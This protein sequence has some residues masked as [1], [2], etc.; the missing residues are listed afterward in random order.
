MAGTGAGSGNRGGTEG[1]A[2]DV[3][4]K[5]LPWSQPAPAGIH[6]LHLYTADSSAQI[7][8][9]YATADA[10]PR[11]ADLRAVW[12]KRWNKRP[13][14][15]LLVAAY[16]TADGRQATVVGLREKPSVGS[17]PIGA[18]ERAIARALEEQDRA[19]A[20]EILAGLLAEHDPDAIPGLVNDGLFATYE[21]QHRVPER[22]DFAGAGHSVAAV[23]KVHGVDV[24]TALGWT[25]TP[26]GS[27]YLLG[28]DGRHEAVAVVLEGSEVFERSSAK[29]GGSTP[30]E[31]ALAVAHRHRVTWVLAV[32]GTLVR[33][34]SADP[35][36]GIA[37][38]GTT[39]HTQFD[40]ALLPEDRLGYVGLLLTPAALRDGGTVSEILS[41]SQDHAAALGARLR[42]R[43]YHEVIPD[44]AEIVAGRLGARSEADLEHA[45]HVTLVILFRLLFVAYAE[46]RDLLPYQSNQ[47][48]RA[49]ALKT[50]ARRYAQDIADGNTRGPEPTAV[51]IWDDLTS[52][53]SAVFHGHREWSIPAYGG[54]LFDPEDPIGQAISGMRLTNDEI[55][56]ALE[57]LLVDTGPDGTQGPVDFQTLSVREFGTIYEGLL[58]SS[59]SLAPTDLTLQERRLRAGR[60][61]RHGVRGRRGR[62]LP[63]RLRGAEGHRF[64]L[65]QG[66]RGRAPARHGTGSVG[67]RAPGAGQGI[68][69]RRPGRGGGHGAVRL[70]GGR[71]GDGLRALPD[72]RDRPHRDPVRGL[73]RRA[74]AP[75]HGGGVAGTARRR[76]QGAQRRRGDGRADDRPHRPDPPSG[77]P[78]C[79]YGIDINRIAS[80][81]PDSPSGS[82]RSFPAFR[83][84]RSITAWWSGTR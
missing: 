4:L 76:G 59:L 15:V 70:Q 51:D 60:Q 52:I 75:A 72:R 21:L 54:S 65:H 17:G 55:S 44:L 49:V 11:V 62:V 67:R 26:E 50:R 46:D 35:D 80:T 47:I 1:P 83:C 81:W 32:K 18:I 78:R 12:E 25:L 22:K 10:R 56:P 20:E 63:Q 68:G 58:E 9:V 84:P 57:Y 61:G 38:K 34:Y 66:V 64:V 43:I 53:W 8:V 16:D 40:L 29:F 24:L 39:T 3:G 48:Y 69:G 7:E 82:T 2:L 23:R 5:P 33:L 14:S 27:D 36:T 45:Y 74:P 13:A 77:G 6:P 19:S 42:D 71:P 79:V 30:V 37:R 28:S 73:P 41:S 31:H